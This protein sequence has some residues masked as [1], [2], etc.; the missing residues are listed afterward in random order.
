[1][2]QQKQADEARA[3]Q[4]GAPFQIRLQRDPAANGGAVAELP[5]PATFTLQMLAPAGSDKERAEMAYTLD[6]STRIVKNKPYSGSGVTDTTQTLADGNKIEHHL[7]NK[8][9][10]DSSGRTRREQTLAALPAS[11]DKPG[12]MQIFL[13]DPVAGTNFILDQ[14]AKTARKTRS[15]HIILDRAPGGD[16]AATVQKTQL[17]MSDVGDAHPGGNLPAGNLT[18]LPPLD[19]AR[20]IR[21][22]ELGEKT[23]SGL[24]CTGK[25]TTI[26]IPAGTVGNERPI[27]ITREVW[28]SRDVEAIVESTTNDPRSGETH[29]LLQNVDR[30]EQPLSLFEPPAEYKM[31]MPD[32]H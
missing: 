10:R 8:Y 11:G 12:E 29:Y 13:Y 25:R 30:G 31:I 21:N 14:G 4:Q 23:I 27:V 3:G 22:E 16:G 19:E 20:D 26:T 18:Q 28:F 24:A 6:V 2:L 5:P 9:Y 1:M 32:K 17:L 15:M 7:E